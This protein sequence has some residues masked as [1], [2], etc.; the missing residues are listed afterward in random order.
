M[1]VSS[2]STY[3]SQ[4]VKE[5]KQQTTKNETKTKTTAKTSESGTKSTTSKT[6]QA[7]V[8]EKSSEVS[9]SQ[10]SSKVDQATIQKLKQEADER[11]SALRE[12]VE[13]VIMKQSNVAGNATDIFSVLRSGDFTVSEEV[14]T[15]AQQEISEDGYWGVKQ[16]SDRLAS[17]AIALCGNDKSKA[18]G[19]IAAFKKGYEAAAKTWGGELPDICKQTYDA[20]LDKMDQ[21]KNSDTTSESATG[22]TTECTGTEAK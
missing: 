6:T 9:K 19:M 15:K 4:Y 12:L 17:F 3:A 11:M 14:K 13:K 7:V 21:W 1:D 8:F 18:D 20:F 22:T 16:T 5:S 10:T 2:I